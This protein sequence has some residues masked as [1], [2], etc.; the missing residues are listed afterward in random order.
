MST[1]DCGVQHQSNLIFYVNVHFTVLC[2]LHPSVIAH[3]QHISMQII[4]TLLL[5]VTKTSSWTFFS[6]SSV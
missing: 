1:I 6:Y 3:V 5:K 4:S 2:F